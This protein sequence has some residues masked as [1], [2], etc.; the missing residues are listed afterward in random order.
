M[1]TREDTIFA[2][3][4]AQGKAGVAIV[5]LSGPRSVQVLETLGVSAPPPRTTRLA[6]L[7][8]R[9]GDLLDHALV[10]HFEEGA[11]FTGE[12]VAELHL[13]GSVA[14]V[15]AVLRVIE[16]TGLARQAEPGEFT[17][18]ALMNDRLDLTQ[19]QGLGDMIAAETEVQRRQ[20]LRIFSGEMAERVTAWRKAI[21]RAAAL[22]EATID[23][24]D[25]DVP[26]DVAPEVMELV[27]G[28]VSGL[29]QEIAGAA[30]ASRI[31]SG[32]EVALVGPPNVG[33]SSLINALTN[34]EAAIVSDVAGT[35]RDV[36][37]VRLDL[38]GLP[39]TILDMA[40]LR[41]S[42]DSIEKVGIERAIQRATTADIR[43]FLREGDIDWDD[44]VAWQDGD[45]RVQ[46]KID[47]YGGEGI[48]TRSGAGIPVLLDALTERLQQ[49][50]A[51]AGLLTTE[52]DLDL[53]RRAVLEL[54]ALQPVHIVEAPEIFSEILRKVAHDLRRVI[55]GV[56]TEAIL[57]EIFSSFCIGK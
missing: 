12:R 43:I 46:T 31:R 32:F 10:L 57:G 30:V 27:E 11:S 15:R 36:I 24:A 20:A 35:T 19:V 17:R 42:T 48:S 54:A 39:V 8:D 49:R 28:V 21:L 45:L 5:R 7:R 33:K 14:I 40:G 50:I 37:E 2:L 51:T 9:N 18:R 4:T 29:R 6:R 44:R 22:V 38:K 56:D 26:V 53:Y 1:A 41:D 55:G 13:H 25:E 52:R 23:F 3:A 16:E 34:S 47:L